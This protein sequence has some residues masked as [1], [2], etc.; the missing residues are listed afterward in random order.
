M[1]SKFIFGRSRIMSVFV[2]CFV[3][4][5]LFFSPSKVVLH[6]DVFM[7]WLQLF[8]HLHHTAAKTSRL[9]MI[10]TIM[11]TNYAG[12]NTYPHAMMSWQFVASGGV[13]Y[14]SVKDDQ[15][16]VDE[17]LAST[18]LRRRGWTLGSPRD[19]RICSIP[20]SDNAAPNWVNTSVSPV[21][22]GPRSSS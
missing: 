17:P 7:L 13:F 12:V 8:V 6:V 21:I 15:Q 9:T 14:T 16:Q 2:S 20:S 3:C 10:A 18:S 19:A 22:L 4:F 11:T 5:F 1:W